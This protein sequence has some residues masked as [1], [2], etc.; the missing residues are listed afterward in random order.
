MSDLL[1][2][3]YDAGNFREEGHRLVDLLADYLAQFRSGNPPVKV[4]N[5]VPPDELFQRWQADLAAGPH[6][7]LNGLFEKILHDT[8]H[9]H[10]PKYLGHQTSN[11]APAAALAEFLGGFLDPGMGVYEQG[12]SGVALERLIVK[13]LARLMD[14]GE[15]ADGFLTSGGTLG[16]LTAMLC[17]RQLMADRDVWKEGIGGHQYGFLVSSE[18]H[19]SIARAV[20]VMGMGS[21]GIVQVPVNDRFQM[22]ADK[23]ESCYEKAQNDGI[24]I[25]GVVS[26]SCAT[27]TGSYDPLEDI[28]DFCEGKKLWLHV[29][30]AHGGCVIY[31]KKYRHLLRGIERADSMIVDF[32]KTL[33][34]PTLV[35]AV[36]FRRSDHSYQ[37]FAQKASYLWDKDEGHEWFNLAKRTFELT[38]SF[39][40][41]RIYAL[42]RTYGPEIFADNVEQLFDLGKIFARLLAGHGNF[43]L[44]VEEPECNIVCYRYVEKS[45]SE[46]KIGQVNAAVREALVQEGEFFIV[47]TRVQEKF[48]LRS[49]LMNPFTTE[50][51]LK[52]LIGK[53][54]DLAK[55]LD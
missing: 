46:E 16:N 51:E 25:L 40:S 7:Q 5:R 39:M 6:F 50:A 10:H 34:T 15:D 11:V 3:A 4:L 14:W 26:S 41:I 12:T 1:R 18:A 27:A 22:R 21:R 32:H 48:F 2:K 23:L 54:S 53:I 13:E 29:D 43:E 33:M 31:S 49:T 30:G 47:Q 45:W 52:E 9:M 38:K 35:T 28:A 20:Q 37:T 44:P 55:Q 19:Y 36:I 8:I 24:T 17:A 42:W